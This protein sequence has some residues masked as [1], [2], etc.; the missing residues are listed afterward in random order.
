MYLTKEQR[1]YKALQDQQRMEDQLE[2][3]RAELAYVT[4]MTGVEI[5]RNRQEKEE[6]TGCGG[7]VSDHPLLVF[8]RQMDGGNG[9]KRPGKMADKAAV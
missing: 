2:N 1:L 3:L 4:M 9:Q 5:S 7:K 6:G 8:T